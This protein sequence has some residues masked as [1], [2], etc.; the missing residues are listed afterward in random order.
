MKSKTDLI[1]VLKYIP[2]SNLSYEEWLGVG[3]ILK[4]EGYDCYEWDEWSRAD[5]RYHEGVCEK[6]WD[7]FDRTNSSALKA[8][9]L[10]NMAKEYGY[11]PGNRYASSDETLS[12]DS[13]IQ[14][15]GERAD[16]PLIQ[17]LGWLET[18]E[19]AESSEVWNE[20]GSNQEIIRYLEALF[21]PTEKV[22]LVLTSFQDEDG[23]YKPKGKGI[24]NQTVGSLIKKLKKHSDLT[25]AIGSYN[26]EAGAWVRFNPLDGEG[27]ANRNVAAYKYALVESDKMPVEQQIAIIKEMR[28]PVAVLVYSGGKSAHAIVRIDAPDERTYRQRVDRLY[29]ECKRNKFEV[30]TQNKNASRLSRLPGVYRKDKRQ[31]ILDTN[32]GCKSWQEWLDWL[33][34]A[35]DNLPDIESMKDVIEHPLE[36]APE[37]IEGILRQGHKMLIS[38][39]SKAGKSFLLMELCVAVAEG[40]KWIGRQ[41]MQGRVLYI[42]L[43]LDKASCG[44]RFL[45]IY[46][47]NGIKSPNAQ[48][49]DIWNLRGKALPLNQLI[50]KL[51]RRARNSHYA[52]IIIDPIYKVIT[53]DENNATD[54]SNFC[55]LFDKICTEL[56]ASAI[57]VHH[58]SKGAQ[59]G[60]K[61]MDR[62][63]GSG[64]FA[65]DP[66]ALLD[67]I[68]IEGDPEDPTT[69]AWRVESTLR[70]F[71]SMQPIDL[72]FHYPIHTLDETGYLKNHFPPDPLQQVND[73][74][75]DKKENMKDEAV[76][77]YDTLAGYHDNPE[78]KLSEI[79]KSINTSERT[80]R[81][82][83]KELS[84]EFGM[85]SQKGGKNPEEGGTWVYRL[86]AKN[87]E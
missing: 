45:E 38:G 64:V 60:K 4:E 56:G 25:D 70:E 29:E 80:V 66:D 5:N 75:K 48:N 1:E 2:P 33:E 72:W 20:E 41:C 61:S 24:H 19:V 10:V 53:G 81:T 67:M 74:K 47:K 71:P 26:H 35:Q 82:Y 14:Y 73:R 52:A 3:M 39:P 37:L 40:R 44:N 31:Y 12:W 32:I 51:L 54:M 77:W 23:K 30:D 62:A 36:L 58:H 50:P 42:N 43:E 11:I 83:F 79:A 46:A 63:S 87:I 84:T 8:G 78:V 57:Y 76:K 13:Y 34:E 86:S 59:I 6:K 18:E 27:V 22:G 7:S 68:E 55:N 17:D 21:E 49:L 65:R 85:R 9:S 15:D 16:A 69:T 28:L